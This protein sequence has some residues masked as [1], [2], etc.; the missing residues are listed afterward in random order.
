MKPKPEC[1]PCF[2]RQMAIAS[3]LAT[4]SK[5]L[6]GKVQ[7]DSKRLLFKMGDVHNPPY[8]ATV[9]FRNAYRLLRTKDPYLP[10][11]DKYNRK[12][13]SLFPFLS[14]LIENSINPL[15]TALK[16]A[17]AGNIID[18]GILER[19]SLSKT[20]EQTLVLRIPDI[21]IA[22][23]RRRIVKAA[24]ILF[25]ADN[26]G[27]IGFDRFLLEQIKSINPS[28][29]IFLSVKKTPIINDATAKDA[30]FFKLQELAKIM[31]SG[32]N[33][34]GTHPHLCSFKFREIFENADF[35]ISKGQANYESLE[36]LADPRIVFLLKAKC[37]VVASNLKVKLND[38]VIKL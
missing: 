32:D 33:W 16:L 31:D 14:K 11:K 30:R 17:L 26:A 29:R 19:F 2:L 3:R 24:D 18:F 10:L 37:P 15:T 13:K 7:R 27:E 21:K 12:V 28:A 5:T 35:I 22:E 6:H 38:I 9:L 8:I 34:I 36:E 23:I 1:T 20:L 4:H 25:I